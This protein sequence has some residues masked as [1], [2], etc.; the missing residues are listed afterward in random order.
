VSAVAAG[1]SRLRLPRERATVAAESVASAGLRL[2]AFTALALF[3]AVHWAALVED[4]PVGRMVIVVLVAAAAAGAL[5]MFGRSSL[6]R[7][8]VHGLALLTVLAA[9]GLA[10]VAAGLPARLLPPGAWD[11]LGV[12]LDR[13]LSGIRNVE[14][15]YDGAEEWVRL[16]IVLGAPLLVMVSAALAFWPAR[17]G[18]GPLRAL[19][20]VALLVLYGIAVTEYERGAPMAR[21]LALFLLV[22]A[23]LWLPRLRRREA[24]AAAVSVLAVGALAVPAAA[25]LDAEAA[26]V[27]YRS[28]NWFG[29]KDLTFEWNHSYGPLDWS[30]EGTT[31]L[32]VRADRPMFWKAETLDL[33]DGR[34][35]ARSGAN[36]RTSPLGELPPQPDRRWDERI[37]VTVRSLETDFVV[38]AGTP[39]LVT[40]AGQAVSGS[41]DGTV[42]R[43]DE[44]LRRGDTY[45][46]RTYNPDPSPREMRA[47]PER[48]DPGLVQYTTVALPG[49][50]TVTV[51]LRGDDADPAAVNALASSAYAGTYRLARELTAGAPTAYDAVRA[52]ERHLTSP[53]FTYTERP[54]VR[55]MPLEAF[56]TRDKV[57]YCQQFSGAMALMLRMAGI[58]A[59]VVSGFAPGS[60]NRDRREFRVR[61]LDAH[62]WVEVWFPQI[63]WVTFDP[64]PA[65]SPADRGGEGPDGPGGDRPQAGAAN[66][67]GDQDPPLP[68]PGGASSSA[69][70]PSRE[71]N[72]G[73]SPLLLVLLAAAVAGAGVALLGR[74]RR[75]NRA[76]ARAAAEASL[77][78]LERALRR[79]GWSLPAGTTLLGLERRLR[80]EAGPAAAAY[81][82]RLRQSRFAPGRTARPP[83][84]QQ[85]RALRRELTAGG[86]PLRRLRG[87]R[88]LPPRGPAF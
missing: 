67:G 21:G 20:L 14:W 80:T 33:F 42:R 59:R 85:R 39:Y 50:P 84:R 27:D 74:R 63:G 53:D 64:T 61:D 32:N 25:R 66:L 37:R 28:W 78:E 55:S 17:R 54:P 23:W 52:V 45:T 35:W 2:A 73:P 69:S 9:G 24:V 6:P 77:I 58:P 48:Y 62:S 75:P 70:G 65:A 5:F 10:L 13:G 56:L 1:M 79:L 72:G 82:A 83:G 8:A 88:A 3:C 81:V 19:G 15:P 36:D 4:R 34:R 47:S 18:V 86:G 16:S 46:V 44:P 22:A 87:Y 7:P 26:V 51:P 57:G 68:G 49:A 40:G 60:F 76:S 31:L 12:E 71:G 29:G 38:G 43:L 11:E 30:R 41:E